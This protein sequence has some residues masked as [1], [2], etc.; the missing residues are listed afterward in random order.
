MLHAVSRINII[1]FGATMLLL[2]GVALA[3][4]T[5][6]STDFTNNGDGTLT[7]KL[8]G[9]TW[10]SCAE[11]Q[12][13]SASSC[14]GSAANYTWTQAAALTSTFAGHNDWRLPRI[15]ELG[16]IVER[17]AINPAINATLFPA[18][19]S[20]IYWSAS[21]ISGSTTDAWSVGFY[22]G[23]NYTAAKTRTGNVR[24]VR[25]GRSLDASGFFTPSVDFTD[26]GNGTV[27]HKKTTLTWKRCTEGQTWSGTTCTGSAQM[28]N[29]PQASTTRTTFGGASDWRL[30]TANELLTILEF[31]KKQPAIEATIFPAIPTGSFWSASAYGDGSD[32][33]WVIDFSSGADSPQYKS[34]S[35]YTRLVRGTLAVGSS[36]GSSS[37]GSG[38]TP[39]PP[40]PPVPL[41]GLVLS[42]PSLVVSGSSVS[43][44]ATGRYN[45]GSTHT[46][47]SAT[48]SVSD[49]TV[50][51]VSGSVL[52]AKTVGT[53]TPLTVT[54]SYTENG[55]TQTA[56]WVLMVSVKSAVAQLANLL[57]GGSDSVDAGK[58]ETYSA[59]AIY[60]DGSTKPQSDIT[61][62][63]TGSAA[64]VDDNG[65]LTALATQATDTTVTLNASYT[66]NGVTKTA[67]KSVAIKGLVTASVC[68]G[69]GTNLSA[70][71]ISVKTVKKLIDSLVVDYCLKS[72][73]S[74][75]K[76][77]LYFAVFL[78]DRTLIFLQSPT[79]FGTPGFTVWDG[80]S[81]PKPYL[82]NTL[83]PDKSG[84]VFQM[85][86]LPLELQTGIYTFYAIPV[87]AGKDMFN[88]FNWVGTLAQDSV[89]VTK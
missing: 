63:V 1:F 5:T 23:S 80:K 29:W 21:A 35:Y 20:S 69:S 6:P 55:V 44:S 81:T 67:K 39:P 34:S 60:A 85:M 71:T 87:S 40:P 33:A 18:T 11:G 4:P 73:D 17:S 82:A 7:H 43:C 53:N 45:D 79:L 27:T 22:A 68:A 13:W 84:T 62:T 30:P 15:D 86:A 77:D 38:S 31:A 74:A 26:N 47:S 3:A 14:T 42:C 12:T 56:S 89:T 88:G 58:T 76:F 32:N 28:W 49:A 2:G 41:I 9:L 70:I 36:S 52:T 24:L 64:S 48:L 10:K 83:L 57:I 54:A 51:S 19:S 61:W 37:T 66:E 50:A 46:V 16:G 59:D 75:A 65:A 25:G 78:P 72:Y 8:T